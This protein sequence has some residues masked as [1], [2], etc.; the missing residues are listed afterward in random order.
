M[1]ALGVDVLG[2]VDDRLGR[3]AEL[4]RAQLVRQPA[5][6]GEREPRERRRDDAVASTP[7]LASSSS[8]PS[9]AS[10]A[11]SSDTVNPMPADAARRRPA[12]A[13]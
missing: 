7:I 12:P 3:R 5:Y 4:A 6:D 2:E 8:G 10:V 1:V 13:R 11:T 9:N